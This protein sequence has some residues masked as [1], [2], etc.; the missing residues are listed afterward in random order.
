MTVLYSQ[1]AS[2]AF[3]AEKA[4]AMK[5]SIASAVGPDS[6]LGDT[7]SLPLHQKSHPQGSTEQSQGWTELRHCLGM[8]TAITKCHY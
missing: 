8:L 2:I 1:L 3:S 6:G 5:V 4:G 7:E